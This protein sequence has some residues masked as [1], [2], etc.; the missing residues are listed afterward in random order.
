MSAVFTTPEDIVNAALAKL[1][2]PIRVG[3]LTEGSVPAKIALDTFGQTRDAMLREGDW[4]FARRDVALTL[5]KQAPAGGYI[6]QTW[7]PVTYPPLPWR[8]AYA[9]P[10]D[11]LKV[12][13]LKK[14]PNFIPDFAPSPIVFDTPNTYISATPDPDIQ[15]KCI[16]CQVPNAILTYTGQVFDPALWEVSFV[17]AMVS[18]MADILA[19]ALDPQSMQ[20]DKAEEEMDEQQAAMVQG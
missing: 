11:C 14:Q 19:P 15:L 18:A 9:Y 4:G 12:R 10:S 3:K 8:Y 20:I 17:Q 1:K 13:A 6:T 16:V 2:A 5:L 7:D